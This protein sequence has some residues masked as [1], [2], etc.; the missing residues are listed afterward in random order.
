MDA[1]VKLGHRYAVFSDVNTAYWVM[2]SLFWMLT[3]ISYTTYLL[4][5]IRRILQSKAMVLNSSKSWD[6]AYLSRMIRRIICQN[7][8]KKQTDHHN[9]GGYKDIPDAKNW[10][11]IPSGFQELEVRKG[12]ESYGVNL[13][14]KQCQWRFWE[15]SGIPC[16][17]VVVGCMHLSRDPDVGVSGWHSREKW[18]SAYK[19]SIKPV[20]G[21]SIWKKTRN[22][23]PL[24]PIIRKM[25]GRPKKE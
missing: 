1:F 13:V 16:V 19:F 24:P 9:V 20:C 18:F 10:V 14:R 21:T 17:H 6:T 2:T 12:D 4:M 15:I 11:V 22:Q 7:H 5:W 8:S 23:P 25:P 3:K